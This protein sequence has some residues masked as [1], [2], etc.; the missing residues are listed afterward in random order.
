MNTINTIK[1]SN[2]N[3]IAIE[4]FKDFNNTTIVSKELYPK[5]KKTKNVGVVSSNFSKWNKLGYLKLGKI[6]ISK[7]NHKK[8][9]YSQE[10]NA[11]RLNL[12][13]LFE[14]FKE[15]NASLNKIEQKK[16]ETFVNNKEIR[17]FIIDWNKKKN[18]KKFQENIY[19][20]LSIFIRSLDWYDSKDILMSAL[21]EKYYKEN[22]K[23]C[24]EVQNII[25]TFV[26][27]V[28]E[29]L[30]ISEK[31]KFKNLTKKEFK[32]AKKIDFLF[33][34]IDKGFKYFPALFNEEDYR[35][36]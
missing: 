3:K 19:E 20:T 35:C 34:E 13:P 16:L 5:S 6:I 1:T 21:G 8:T 17:N 24:L 23:Q 27:E 18:K 2:E 4:F 31:K 29:D 10:I 14:I 22:S 11:Y 30:T 28:Y 33:S 32:K 7:I 15:N 9:K 26:N 25:T 12:K 36:D